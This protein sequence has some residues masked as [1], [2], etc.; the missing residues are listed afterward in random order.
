MDPARA[1][2]RASVP[3]RRPDSARVHLRRRPK[4]APGGP[5]APVPGPRGLRAGASHNF[6]SLDGPPVPS[7]QPPAPW[8]T[9]CRAAPAAPEAL[10]R[11]LRE[12]R[13]TRSPTR[14]LR[15]RR[16]GGRAHDR[17]RTGSVPVPTAPWG[18]PGMPRTRPGPRAV[19]IPTP[20][21]A[22]APRV[23]YPRQATSRPALR[24]PKGR[25]ESPLRASDHTPPRTAASVTRA[26]LLRAPASH[27]HRSRRIADAPPTRQESQVR[28]RPD[29][30][31]AGGK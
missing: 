24:R 31:A 15:R 22:E 16:E 19:W 26:A 21:P 2:R 8:C 25:R 3:S 27:P 17:R 20:R 30:V 10:F 12:P 1:S 14:R 28:R 18:S 7:S 9:A 4:R 13:L 5:R 6:P 11:L 29:S 23:G